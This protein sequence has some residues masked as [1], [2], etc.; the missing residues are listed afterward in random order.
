M[1]TCAS[2]SGARSE[3]NT[4][5]SSSTPAFL[6]AELMSILT[7]VLA[8]IGLNW[9]VPEKPTKHWMM[10]HSSVRAAKRTPHRDPPLSFLCFMRSSN[11]HYAPLTQPKPMHREPNC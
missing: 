4:E 9:A 1:S 5:K 2:Y 6:D 10:G 11:G 3:A 8:D 7:E